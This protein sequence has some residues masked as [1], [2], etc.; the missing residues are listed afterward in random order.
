ML[1]RLQF[2]DSTHLNRVFHSREI[3]C[4][5]VK[6]QNPSPL[7]S[8]GN[9]I[10]HLLDDHVL[11]PFSSVS[12]KQNQCH[13]NVG[14]GKLRNVKER[15]KT[16]RCLFVFC[17]VILLK[18][19]KCGYDTALVVMRRTRPS[20]TPVSE[21]QLFPN[22]ITSKVFRHSG[23]LWGDMPRWF[24]M[25]TVCNAFCHWA[26][27]RFGMSWYFLLNLSTTA[28]KKL[29]SSQKK[30]VEFSIWFEASPDNM[31]PTDY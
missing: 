30:S 22:S 25:A 31:I 24:M 11:L 3:T 9:S 5:S 17:F 20:I 18:L 15:R 16:N 19:Q 14:A 4:C 6:R 1:S 23:L 26:F 13:S 27:K 10:F 8:V 12:C 28:A 2:C 29:R 21:V 7:A